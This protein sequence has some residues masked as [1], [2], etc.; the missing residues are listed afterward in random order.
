MD[1]ASLDGVGADALAD[2]DFTP[3]LSALTLLVDDLDVSQEFY[4]RVFGLQPV[5]RDDHSIGYNF[6]SIVVNLLASR[7]GERLVTPA[8]V[9]DR[10]SGLR[11]QLSI[12]VDDI[13]T[14]VEILRRRGV[15]LDT[16]PT[17]QPWNMRTAT[18]RDPDGHS[19]EVAQDLS[20]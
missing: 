2:A 13:D 4:T 7:E 10:S 14:V 9:G 5:W 11:S 3:A 8:P 16:E 19:W 1:S 6:A 17:D 20:I 15:S 18:F 12:W